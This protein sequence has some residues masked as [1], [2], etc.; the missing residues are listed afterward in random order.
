MYLFFD[1]ETT[2]LPKNW[3]APLTDLDNWP[4]LVQIAWIQYDLA[5]KLSSTGNY[6]I[7]PEAFTIP[8]DATKI[9]R[10]S[11]EKALKEGVPLKK[12]LQEF[13]TA[14]K[15]SSFLVAHKLDFDQN[16]IESEFLR[17]GIEHSLSSI[18]KVCTMK[19]TTDFC[20]IPNS[21]GYKWP[22]LSELH[23]KLF[24]IGFEDTHNALADVT[25]C[26]K[27]FFELKKRGVIKLKTKT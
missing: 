16:I 13:S 6:I 23:Q 21:Y 12:A 18:T 9:H 10:I 1:T 22:T 25:A 3:K 19:S 7:R 26:A 11:T 17:T 20:R 8:S 4:R 2:G 14:L 27:C 5:G 15:N 24:Q